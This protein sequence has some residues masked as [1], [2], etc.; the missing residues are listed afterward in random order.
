MHTFIDTAAHQ[1]NG[2]VE[3]R[4]G[5]LNKEV[6]SCLLRS[7]LPHYLWKNLLPSHAL[8]NRETRLKARNSSSLT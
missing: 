8:L 5:L 6:R 3:R 4:I 2:L 1:P 7:G